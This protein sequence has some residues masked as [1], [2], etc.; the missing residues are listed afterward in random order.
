MLELVALRTVL[1][2]SWKERVIR[3]WR[4]G[5]WAPIKS[6]SASPSSL[7]TV[8]TE[9]FFW[10][11]GFTWGEVVVLEFGDLRTASVGLAPPAAYLLMRRSSVAAGF[12]RLARAVS[13]PPAICGEDYY[14]RIGYCAACMLYCF[15]WFVYCLI[16]IVWTGRFARFDWTSLCFLFLLFLFDTTVR[17]GVRNT[18]AI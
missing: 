11:R 12:G 18:R 13:L 14:W 6:E 3:N 17:L 1:L 7:F 15:C 5:L 9:A 8:I 16:M 10:R 2:S 4:R